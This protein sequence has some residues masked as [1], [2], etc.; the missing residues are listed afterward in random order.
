MYSFERFKN[1]VVMYVQSLWKFNLIDDVIIDCRATEE[2]NMFLPKE[3]A[4]A[5]R[6]EVVN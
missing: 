4:F 5:L 3:V 6:I 1:E 2:E